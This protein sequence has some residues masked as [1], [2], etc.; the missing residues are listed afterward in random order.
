MKLT[1]SGYWMDF[2]SVLLKFNI[3]YPQLYMLKEGVE[4]DH[5]MLGVKGC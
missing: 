1:A 3:E 2:D 5:Y 4:S